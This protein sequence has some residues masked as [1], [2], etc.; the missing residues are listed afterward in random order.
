MTP[1][2]FNTGVTLIIDDGLELVD[3]TSFSDTRPRFLVFKVEKPD[4][5]LT[6]LLEEI[7]SFVDLRLKRRQ[8]EESPRS[9]EDRVG[10]PV[11]LTTI[12]DTEQ[13]PSCRPSGQSSAAARYPGQAPDLSP[14]AQTA[15]SVVIPVAAR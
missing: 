9:A 15:H 7:R 14:D 1:R 13:T 3:V 11:D 6:S 10:C 2:E 8:S 5:A 12:H 4:A